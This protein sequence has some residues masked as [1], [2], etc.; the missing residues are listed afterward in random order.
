MSAETR[1]HVKGIPVY[2]NGSQY[3]EF[4]IFDR[5]YLKNPY[6]AYLI[7]YP[8]FLSLNFHLLFVS[9]LWEREGKTPEAFRTWPTEKQQKYVLKRIKTALKTYRYRKSGPTEAICVDVFHTSE[10]T[11]VS[12]FIS[13]QIQEA[14]RCNLWKTIQRRIVCPD[15]LSQGAAFDFFQDRQHGW[16]ESIFTRHPDLDNPIPATE[17]LKLL[18]RVLDAPTQD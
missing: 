11:H 13:G 4:V 10:N 8:H 2:W 6:V 5:F 15:S 12:A 1:L 7:S 17:L 14:R 3:R 18:N 16:T 9:P